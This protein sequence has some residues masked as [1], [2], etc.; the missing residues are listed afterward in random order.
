MMPTET[1]RIFTALGRIEE[2]LD[3]FS[4]RTEQRLAALEERGSAARFKSIEERLH[5]NDRE[6]TTLRT[7]IKI[8]VALAGALGSLAG[9]L[10]LKFAHL[11]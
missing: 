7:Q 3:D 11:G 9:P 5:E 10:I 1:D 6:L 8:Y 2:K 4:R